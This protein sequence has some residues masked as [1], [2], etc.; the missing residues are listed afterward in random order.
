MVGPPPRLRRRL[1]RLRPQRAR[2]PHH[3]PP[4][5]AGVGQR[6]ESPRS[7]QLNPP[8]RSSKLNPPPRSSKLNPP[9]RSSR[10]GERSREPLTDHLSPTTSPHLSSPHLNHLPSVLFF[11]GDPT[12][13]S[14]SKP[15]VP[16][17][18]AGLIH[19]ANP[20]PPSTHPYLTRPPL[21]R[22]PTHT[23]RT[24]RASGAPKPP[25]QNQSR[26]WLLSRPRPWPPP[27]RRSVAVPRAGSHRFPRPSPLAELKAEAEGAARPR[28]VLMTRRYR[29]STRWYVWCMVMVWCMVVMWVHG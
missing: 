4:S 25:R 3:H 12:P 26:W 28:A 27:R 24:A 18:P 16:T 29:C 1:R 5:V 21:P 7:K 19:P 2:R 22:A 13:P 23:P 17:A 20:T 14:S 8:R 9:P 6:A 10:H 11:A 15:P